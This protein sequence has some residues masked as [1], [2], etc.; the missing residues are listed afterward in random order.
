MAATH[1]GAAQEESALLLV[2]LSMDVVNAAR[3]ARCIWLW[4]GCFCRVVC[5]WNQVCAVQFV[6]CPIACG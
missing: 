2:V 5:S 4:N 3:A 1:C 6:C